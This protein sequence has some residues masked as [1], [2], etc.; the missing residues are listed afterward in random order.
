MELRHDDNLLK[1][2]LHVQITDAGFDNPSAAVVAGHSEARGHLDYQISEASHLKADLV[3]TQDNGVATASSTS[4]VIQTQGV[5]VAVQTKLSPQVTTELGLR[6]GQTDTT[7]ATGFNY[8]SVSAGAPASTT[9]PASAATGTNTGLV[10]VRGRVTTNVPNMPNTQLFA[11]AEQDVNDSTRHV[12]AI[13]ANY[14]INDKARVYGRYELIS[15]LNGEY[16][17]TSGVQRNVG[18][19]GVESAYMAGGRVYDEYRIADT[20]DGRAMQS[21]MG[22][23]NTFEVSEGLRLTGG[24]EQVSSLPSASGTSSGESKAITAAFDWLGTGE[25]KKRLRGSGSLEFRDG[26]DANSALMTLGVAYKFNPDWSLLT[27]AALN[28]VDSFTDGSTH[29][30]EREQIGFA[31]RP[32]D[33]DEWNTLLRY[34]HKVDSWSGV[35]TTSLPPVNTSTDIVSAHLNYQPGRRDIVSARI[36]AKQSSTYSD[37]VNSSYG[38]QLMYARWTHDLS[39]DWDFGLQAGWLMGDGNTQQQSLG[40]EIGYQLSKGLWLSA[41]Y[42][43]V[44]L[45]DPDLTGADYTDSGAYVRLRFKF[46]ERLFN[47]SEAPAAAELR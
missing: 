6:A 36:A 7:A 38:A 35:L 3:Y 37:G 40:A 34:E 43:V 21:A 20:I 2:N 47:K 44:G 30:Q 25:Y 41:G 22:V 15:S 1:Y 9:T 32:V 17:L 14:A 5:S 12:A 18:L 27:R 39:L 16:A 29:W 11:E 4:N 46:D 33:Q 23:R 45:H 19:V 26:S 42:N 28:K 13:G 8:G 31:Y 24:L 10:S